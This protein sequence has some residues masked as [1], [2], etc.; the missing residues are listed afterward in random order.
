MRIKKRCKIPPTSDETIEQL[1]HV[2]LLRKSGDLHILV[3][4]SERKRRQVH[5]GCAVYANFLVFIDR[6]ADEIVLAA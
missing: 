1:G 3:G 5:T 4:G 6:L 2:R